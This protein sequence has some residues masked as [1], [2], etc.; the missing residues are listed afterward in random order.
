MRVAELTDPYTEADITEIPPFVDT[1]VDMASLLTDVIEHCWEVSKKEAKSLVESFYKIKYKGGDTS[2]LAVTKRSAGDAVSTFKSLDRLHNFLRSA[3]P[4]L[5]A[6]DW[7]I[8][9]AQELHQKHLAQERINGSLS[10]TD[11]WIIAGD[12]AFKVG[13]KKGASLAAGGFLARFLT[14]SSIRYVLGA[15]FVLATSE[16]TIP[17]YLLYIAGTTV[18]SHCI[19]SYISEYVGEAYEH[20][21]LSIAGCFSENP[22][23]YVQVRVPGV[24]DPKVAVLAKLVVVMGHVPSE[25]K[26]CGAAYLQSSLRQ[27]GYIGT[28]AT[29]SAAL[30]NAS[31]SDMSGPA[32]QCVFYLSDL[33]AGRPSVLRTIQEYTKGSSIAVQWSGGKGSYHIK[34]GNPKVLLLLGGAW[35]L[36]KSIKETL[37]YFRDSPELKAVKGIMQ[38]LR[39]C[40]AAEN[41]D[42]GWQRGVASVKAFVTRGSLRNYDMQAVRQSYSQLQKNIATAQETNVF[43]KDDKYRLLCRVAEFYMERKKSQ[44]PAQRVLLLQCF[45]QAFKQKDLKLCAPVFHALLADTKFLASF[46]DSPEA[47]INRANKLLEER[48]FPEALAAVQL[49][50]KNLIMENRLWQSAPA[51]AEDFLDREEYLQE[52][53]SRLIKYI[54]FAGKMTVLQQSQERVVNLMHQ[55]KQ[56]QAAFQ[57]LSRVITRV[58]DLSGPIEGMD[59]LDASAKRNMKQGN[60]KWISTILSQLADKCIETQPMTKVQKERILQCAKQIESASEITLGARRNLVG[61]YFSLNEQEKAS[62][63]LETINEDREANSGDAFLLAVQRHKEGRYESACEWYKTSLARNKKEGGLE[64]QM[65]LWAH[66]KLAY[67]YL[68]QAARN[69]Q[70]FSKFYNRAYEKLEEVIQH[71]KHNVEDIYPFVRLALQGSNFY[72][73]VRSLDLLLQE[74][75]CDLEET[76]V[77]HFCL[78]MGYFTRSHIHLAEERLKKVDSESIKEFLS[79]RADSEKDDRI[80]HQFRQGISRLSSLEDQAFYAHL[81]FRISFFALD[82][83]PVR[84]ESK[85][86]FAALFAVPSIQSL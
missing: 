16:F 51:N 77:I 29:P 66:R 28:F 85:K 27:Y 61:L 34:S 75:P 32:S 70:D 6:V 30:S 84:S 40:I 81:L 82:K 74:T 5:H 15:G 60:W 7:S 31:F 76:A 46:P 43:Q 4:V 63:G 48:K 14:Q 11:N 20:C 24:V 55:P 13:L 56:W 33:S 45:H 41:K 54:E 78:A 80:F 64:N 62:Q 8:E 69:K 26:S 44:D 86:R 83:L 17:T 23:C 38:A 36:K 39:N 49:A 12:S 67:C 58:Q 25:Y 79:S 9:F 18:L 35:A 37:A 73:C 3:G 68:E 52:S 10:A 50:N 42:G 1:M 57:E 65:T 19:E 59:R 71:P 22:A 53:I 21:K 47:Q 72:A 2:L